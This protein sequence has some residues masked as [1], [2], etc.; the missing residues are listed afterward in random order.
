MESSSPA[1]ILVVAHKTAA[2]PA[3]LEAVRQRADRGPAWFHLLV[4]NP[5]PTG[6]R[7]ARAG[8]PEVGDGEQVL[9]LALPLIEEATHRPVDGSVSRRHDPMDAIEE[10]LY[11]GDFDEII[12]ST[13]PRSVSRWLHMDLPRRV[14][15]LGL[16][17]TTVVARER[18]GA[19]SPAP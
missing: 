18:D 16:P 19:T 15:H 11:E 2:T 14:A 12:L 5:H 17:V 6:W 4:P 10:A 7:P 8:H 13:L 1:H 3:L 9:A